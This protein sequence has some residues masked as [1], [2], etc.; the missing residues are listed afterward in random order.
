[1][2]KEKYKLIPIEDYVHLNRNGFPC[3]NGWK[4]KLIQ[5]EERTGQKA[6]FEWEK[7]QNNTFVK[8]KI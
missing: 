2:D 1:M 7:K 6:P 4:Y 5:R 8:V 3:T